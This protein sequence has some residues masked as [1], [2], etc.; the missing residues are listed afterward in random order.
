MAGSSNV[1]LIEINID[2]DQL[3][4][5]RFMLQYVKG[6]AVKAVYRALNKTITGVVVDAAKAISGDINISQKRVK[7]DISTDKANSMSLRAAIISKG[8]KI[9]LIEFGARQVAQGVTFQVK[10]TGTRTQMHY[11]FIGAGKSTGKLH[12]LRRKS[13][14]PFVG[15]GK[16]I[17]VPKSGYLWTFPGAWG[18]KYREGTRIKYGPSIPDI[19]GRADIFLALESSGNDRLAKNLDHEADFLFSQNQ[20]AGDGSDEAVT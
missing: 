20:P 6:G 5:V 7:Q 14:D 8:K 17:G 16:A 10:K 9:E 2:K 11:G 18:A 4:E 1:N 15:K 3:E 13:D 19:M 12:V